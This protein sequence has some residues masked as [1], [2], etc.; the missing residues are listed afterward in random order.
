MRA[1]P[2]GD[3]GITPTLQLGIKL[4]LRSKARKK[5]RHGIRIVTRAVQVLYAQLVCFQLLTA[6]IAESEQL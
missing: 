1:G 5:R 3:R 4:V 6:G 2:F